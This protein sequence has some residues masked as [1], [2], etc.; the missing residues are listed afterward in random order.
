[1][2]KKDSFE[3][4]EWQYVELFNERPWILRYV[5]KSIEEKIRILETCIKEKRPIDVEKDK[6]K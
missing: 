2:N 3:K 1:M 6:L 4:L 5:E